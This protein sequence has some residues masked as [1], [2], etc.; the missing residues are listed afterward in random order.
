MDIALIGLVSTA[1]LIVVALRALSLCRSDA[2]R[3]DGDPVVG[4]Q[5]HGRTY[6]VARSTVDGLDQRS[7]GDGHTTFA[8][9]RLSIVAGLTVALALL[10]LLRIA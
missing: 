5:R 2:A 9:M 1:T 4:V 7:S 6:Y 8:G 10:T 3:N